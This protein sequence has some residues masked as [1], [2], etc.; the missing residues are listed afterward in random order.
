M[1]KEGWPERG[2][3]CLLWLVE[4]EGGKVEGDGAGENVTEGIRG[5]G[6]KDDTK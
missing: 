6:E 5:R 1:G 4:E 2:K 3:L